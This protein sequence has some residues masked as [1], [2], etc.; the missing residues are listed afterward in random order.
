[1]AWL[2][3]QLLLRPV[4]AVVTGVIADEVQAVRGTPGSAV[5]AAGALRARVVG[6][7]R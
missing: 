3:A 4:P 2:S 5:R 1:M 7:R 6:R